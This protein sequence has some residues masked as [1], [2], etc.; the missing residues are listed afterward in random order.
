LSVAFENR[1]Q[2]PVLIAGFGSIGRRHFRN[3]QALGCKRFVFYR[4][5]QGTVPDDELAEW[6]AVNDLD[7]AWAHGPRIAVI[8]G[9]SARHVQVA[10]AAA[11]AGCDLFVEKPLSASLEG[12]EELAE[13][14]RRRGLV[15]MI[16]C[17]FRFHPLLIRLREKLLSG[18][19]GAVIGARAEWGEYLPDW[20]PWEDYRRSYSARTE[21]GGGVVLTLIHPLDYLYWLLGPVDRVQASTRGVAA[22]ETPAG[23]DWAEIVLE[24]NSGAVA[25]VHLDYVQRPAVHRLTVWG[26]R[27]RADLDFHAGIL[28]WEMADGRA[29]T[30]DTVGTEY[31][32]NAMFLAEMRHFL[33]CV[34]S[35]R[36]PEVPLSD[37]IAVLKVALEAK[38][39]AR[40]GRGH[41]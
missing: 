25:Q 38:R 40:E 21:L 22:L 39:F 31:D 1:L 19:L 26:E 30:T 6:P 23:E 35:R 16:G 20:H 28:R 41:G 14:V 18:E 2:Q 29:A 27:G 12:C 33:D 7:A 24:F 3:L 34:E 11:S 10:Q 13:T 37:G 9:P 5:R 17:Q 32:R 36:P 15:A 4:T 8:A